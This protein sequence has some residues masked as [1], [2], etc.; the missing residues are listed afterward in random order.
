MRTTTIKHPLSDE[1]FNQDILGIILSFVHPKD[2][3]SLQLVSKKLSICNRTQ[4]DSLWRKYYFERFTFMKENATK[5]GI[6]VLQQLSTIE[7]SSCNFKNALICVSKI[8]N[9]IQKQFPYIKYESIRKSEFPQLTSPS[10]I[11]V[12]TIGDGGS[13]RCV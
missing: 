11:K 4:D 6:Q 3:L 10:T 13:G 2:L 7:E 9:P 1:V 12:V 5:K 8:Y